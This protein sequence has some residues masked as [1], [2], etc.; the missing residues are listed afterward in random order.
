MFGRYY[1]TLKFHFASRKR[2]V[3]NPSRF[4]TAPLRIHAKKHFL[5]VFYATILE[6]KQEFLNNSLDQLWRTYGVWVLNNFWSKN[7]TSLE[8]FSNLH[9]HSIVHLY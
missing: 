7:F 6:P 5:C 4:M 1:H 2:A 3:I 9:V 8:I